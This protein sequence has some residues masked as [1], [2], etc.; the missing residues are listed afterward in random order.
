MC[1]NVPGKK[2][3]NAKN[4]A[5]MI[6]DEVSIKPNT[7]LIL[8]SSFLPQ[9]WDTNIAPPVFMPNKNRF[10]RNDAWFDIAFIAIS[11]SPTSESN[12]VSMNIPVFARMFSIDT[13]IAI[14]RMSFT[15]LLPPD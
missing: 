14:F 10:T 7:L 2:K 6:I 1:T 4:A 3:V 13:G 11:L 12:I 8:S 5:A 9:Y 15:K